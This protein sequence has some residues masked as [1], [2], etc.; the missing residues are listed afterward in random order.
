M[1]DPSVFHHVQPLFVCEVC[2]SLQVY[3]Y[4]LL[5]KYMPDAKGIHESMIKHIQHK[6]SFIK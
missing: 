4:E 5:L 1:F 3:K 2:Q 6:R